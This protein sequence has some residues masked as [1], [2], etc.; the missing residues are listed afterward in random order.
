[1][2]AE[3]ETTA[4]RPGHP[5]FKCLL[6]SLLALALLVVLILGCGLLWLRSQSAIDYALGQLPGLLSGTGLSVNI[7]T[8]EGP[9][10][11]HL[12]LQ[13]VTVHDQNGAWLKIKELELRVAVWPLLH[14]VARLELIR[15][16]T[17]DLLRLPDLPAQKETSPPAADDAQSPLLL[18]VAVELNDFSLSD[19]SLAWDVLGFTADNPPPPGIALNLPLQ[20]N[21]AAKGSLENGLVQAQAELT[22]ISGPEL[23]ARLSLPNLRLNLAGTGNDSATAEILLA[24]R[25]GT[26]ADELTLSLQAQD[27][28]RRLAISRCAA[29]GMGLTISGDGAWQRDT[30]ALNANLIISS[31]AQAPWQE[32]ATELGG[33]DKQ[34]LAA[35]A[36]PLN[37]NIT[38]NGQSRGELS[39][40]LAKLRVGII[41]GQGEITANIN[42]WRAGAAPDKAGNLKANLD[43]AAEDLAPLGGGVSGPLAV[44]LAADGNMRDA[45]LSLDLS[46]AELKT[47]AGRLEQFAARL[48]GAFNVDARGGVNASGKLKASTASSPG[49]ATDISTAWQVDL[50]GQDA[51]TP[52]RAEARDLALFAFG[53]DLNGNLV[54]EQEQKKRRAKQRCPGRQPLVAARPAPGWRH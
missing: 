3:K 44:K 31:A 43:L 41:A 32:L 34:L 28:G 19:A 40:N 47:G 22:A 5:A 29:Q 52:L 9:L 24:I 2:H 14:G 25:R 26:R 23:E 46:S 11:Q 15:I 17:P 21:L 37:L 20:L 27:D 36:D 10:P 54:V 12:L 45:Q 4:R 42:D 6:R 7:E 16:D 30:D 1:M 13:G 38:L 51:G 35:L 53:V 33:V 50:P 49:G 39:L 48:S 8:A 18:P